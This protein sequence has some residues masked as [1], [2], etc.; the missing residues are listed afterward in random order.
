MDYPLAIS[1]WDDEEKRVLLEVIES[2]RYTMGDRVRAYEDAFAA[3]FG[4]RYAVMTSSGS[5]ANLIALEALRHHPSLEFEDGDEV[6][7][8]A[9]SWSTTYF[10][11]NQAKLKLR[12]VDIDPHTLNIDLDKLE[13]AITP[14]TKLVFGVNLLGNPI[15]AARVTKICSQHGVIFAEDNCESMGATI[16]G[17]YCGTHG[18]FGTFSTY[19]SHH[20]C[21]MEGGM[22]VTNDRQ[23]RDNLIS[24][25]AHGWVRDLASDSHLMRDFD[26]FEKKFRF[27][28][29]GYNVRPLEME[30]ALGIPQLKKLDGF[31][32]E[33]RK[34]A[35]TFKELIGDLPSMRIQ[36]ET[37]ESSWF[38]FSL[39][40]EDG[41]ADKR[42]EIISEL[43]KKKIETRPVVTGNFLKNPV[44]DKLDYNIGSEISVADEVDES[45]FFVGNHQ[46]PIRDRIEYLHESL[47]AIRKQF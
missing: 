46:Q 41:L 24:L 32:E 42:K 39:V 11:V 16:D 47:D 4:S 45:G 1:T 14:R 30:G 20:L 44:I 5:T 43:T 19:F 18:L 23:L 26:E 3:K 36:Q 7:V 27:V 29:P 17:R 31:I 21:T 8:P 15:D 6:I 37:G 38:G 13:A 25:R 28:L 33:R 2:D 34:N 12:F 10:P 35:V 40:L 22:V 9:V